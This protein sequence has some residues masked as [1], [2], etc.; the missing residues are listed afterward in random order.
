MVEFWIASFAF[1]ILR[2]ARD[3]RRRLTSY[4]RHDPR[5]ANTR[6]FNAT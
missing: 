6:M 5:I 4:A 1:R 2:E 3:S